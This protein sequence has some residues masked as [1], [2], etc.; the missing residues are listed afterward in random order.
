VVGVQLFSKI[1]KDKDDEMLNDVVNFRDFESS[2]VLLFRAST[3]E[4][5]NSIMHSLKYTPE[6]CDPDPS[7][8]PDMVRKIT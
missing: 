8:D 7:F 4:A 3:G 6:G 1:G 5:W 2:I